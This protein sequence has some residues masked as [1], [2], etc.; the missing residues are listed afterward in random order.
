M[1]IKITDSVLLVEF[2][3]PIGPPDKE[4]LTLPCMVGVKHS[5]HQPQIGPTA[6]KIIKTQRRGYLLQFIA[7]EKFLKRQ[8]TVTPA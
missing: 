6:H 7:V 2:A 8:G 3:H 5:R 1:V 4:K